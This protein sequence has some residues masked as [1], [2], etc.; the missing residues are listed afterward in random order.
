MLN[1]QATVQPLQHIDDC[2]GV[3]RSVRA[4]Q[5]LQGAPAV[6]DS[7]VSGDSAPVLEAQDPLETHRSFHGTVGDF[8][9]LCRY[10]EAAVEPWKKVL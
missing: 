2:S 9:H 3:A 5:Q 8:Q 10:L 1:F 4:R 6:S 7:V